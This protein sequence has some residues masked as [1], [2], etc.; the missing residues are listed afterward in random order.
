MI[1]MHDNMTI[2]EPN[3]TFN[4]ME[5]GSRQ[6]ITSTDTCTFIVDRSEP[7]DPDKIVW[8]VKCNRADSG[9]ALELT[10]NGV[11]SLGL[12]SDAS[13]ITGDGDVNY[14]DLLRLAEQWLWVGSPGGIAEDISEDGIVN[15][16]DFALLAENWDW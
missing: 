7:I 5:F 11:D 3:V 16:A 10:I 4:D 2:V 14:D 8:K 1:Q 6:S 12:E 13:D 9:M 15:F